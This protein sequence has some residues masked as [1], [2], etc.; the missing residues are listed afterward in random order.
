MENLAS[1]KVVRHC[2]W[3]VV[4]CLSIASD[5]SSCGMVSVVLLGVGK[6]HH[7]QATLTLDSVFH[8]GGSC[9]RL[10]V[11][12]SVQGLVLIGEGVSC[13]VTVT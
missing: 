6:H 1:L 7:Q 4:V 9:S 11:V 10:S 13:C 12:L 3:C 5:Y 2:Q 8:G